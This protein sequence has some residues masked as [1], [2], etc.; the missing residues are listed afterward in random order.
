MMSRLG[1]GCGTEV[2]GGKVLRNLLVDGNMEAAGTQRG[3]WNGVN[4]P[5][6]STLI[7]SATKVTI[8]VIAPISKEYSE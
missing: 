8:Y 3:W 5:G 4:D 7:E 6:G 1:V 2:V